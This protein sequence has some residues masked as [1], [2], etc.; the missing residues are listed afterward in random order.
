MPPSFSG[1]GKSMN[2]NNFEDIL[3]S[4]MSDGDLMNKI[5]GIVKSNKSGDVANSLPDVI[6]ALSPILNGDKRENTESTEKSS[7]EKDKREDS[8]NI[9]N[10]TAEVLK[11]DSGNILSMLAGGGRSS[12]LL[13]ALKPY[14]SRERR[15]MIDTI[16]RVS[17]I[18]DIIKTVR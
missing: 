2:E 8:E 12:K 10:A 17:Q 18:A 13:L 6:A 9:E 11:K 5:S 1:R 16:V 3:S 4:V 14:V 15:D 7:L